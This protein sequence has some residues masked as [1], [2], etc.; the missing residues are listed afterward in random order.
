MY[1]WPHG[2]TKGGVIETDVFPTMTVRSYKDNNLI[3]EYEK[4]ESIW[5]GTDKRRD[6]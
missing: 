5:T 1:I 6:W 2:Y 3:I 4:D